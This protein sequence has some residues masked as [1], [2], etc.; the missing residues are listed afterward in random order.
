MRITATALFALLASGCESETICRADDGCAKL[1]YCYKQPAGEDADEEAE[2]FPYLPEGVCRQDC[3]TDADC[4]GSFRCNEKGLC[5]D[6]IASSQRQWAGYE[7]PM[8]VLIAAYS[9][10]GDNCNN[11]VTCLRAAATP[12]ETDLCERSADIDSSAPAADLW[13]CFNEK[14]E[15]QEF[16]ACTEAE[17]ANELLLCSEN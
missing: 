11:T 14:C 9:T 15:D 12:A 16:E 17:C 1:Y 7:T 10:P 4:S 6:L 5:K 8:S 2:G 13:E 3:T